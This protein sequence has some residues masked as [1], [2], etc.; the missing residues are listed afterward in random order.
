MQRSWLESSVRKTPTIITDI[1]RLMA[2]LSTTWPSSTTCKATISKRPVK[3]GSKSGYTSV[4]VNWFLHVTRTPTL[5]DSCISWESSSSSTRRVPNKGL[6]PSINHSSTATMIRLKIKLTEQVVR[7][8]C[9]SGFRPNTNKK[10]REN[11][12]RN[13]D[14]LQTLSSQR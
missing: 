5:A 4:M 2:D 1:S 8:W 3:T 12:L 6:L 11:Y 14:R 13:W 9:W 10:P 7:N